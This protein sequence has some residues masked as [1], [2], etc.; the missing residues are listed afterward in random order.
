[1]AVAVP[2]LQDE[3]G[4]A[5]NAELA[6][7]ILRGVAQAQTEVNLN[8]FNQKKS[9]DFTLPGA[10]FLDPKSLNGKG[11]KVIIANDAN[12]TQ[13]AKNVA[14]T[15]AKRSKILGVVGHWTSEMTTATVDIYNQNK[16]PIVSPGTTTSELTKQPRSFFFRSTTNN[17]VS[18]DVAIDALMSDRVNQRRVAV[19]YNP[20]SPY[21]SDYKKRFKE[22]FLERGGEIVDSFDISRPNF[23]VQSAIQR[24]R[25]SGELG[26]VLMPDGQV[27]DALFNALEI[28][29]ENGGQNWIV[30][31]WSVYTPKTLNIAQPQLVEKLIVTVPWHPLS[32][33]S[34]YFSQTSEQLWGGPVSSRTVL[35]YDAAQVLIEGIRQKPTRLGIQNILADQSFSLDGVTG[36][37]KFK[38]G[39]GDRQKLPFELVK[40]VPC[41]NQMFG[42]AFIPVKF[43]TP[44]DAG[45]NCS[46]SV[47]F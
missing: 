18:T 28:I 4:R 40:I 38:P 42:F 7:E 20:A 29:K 27:T 36:K 41:P 21:S 11:L 8:L 10:N 37:I 15:I 14:N 1:M 47:D 30:G 35:S 24:I 6:E 26:I 22:K 43:S 13:Q 3:T 46:S 23:D 5:S 39:T 19:F 2:V 32:N 33:P 25:N 17:Y 44:E 31:N 9:S 45:L 12:L 34:S 16:L